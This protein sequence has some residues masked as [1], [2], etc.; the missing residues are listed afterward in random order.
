LKE[1]SVPLNLSSYFGSDAPTLLHSE[2]PIGAI[3]KVVV[4]DNLIIVSDFHLMKSL[5]VFNSKGYLIRSRDDIGEEGPMG[6]SEI[7]DFDVFNG[8]IFVLDAHKRKIYT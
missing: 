6:M 3:D 5:K 8:Y 2:V 4:T 7:T 1:E